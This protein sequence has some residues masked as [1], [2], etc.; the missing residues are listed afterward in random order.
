MRRVVE[1]GCGAGPLTRAS[2]DANFDVTGIDLS[3]ELVHMARTACP[4]AEFQ[5]GS[6]YTREIPACEAIVAIGEPLTYHDADDGDA[7]VRDFF[8]RASSLLPQGALLIFDL[9]ELG[10]PP[11]SGR[12]WRAGED[13]AV[14]VEITEN[15]SSRTVV[16]E[17]ET[18]RKVGE[19][20]RRGRE[21][22]RV[23][24][25]ETSEV[26]SWLEAAGFRVSTDRAFGDFRLP[27]RRHAFFCTRR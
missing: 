3:S 14:L 1:V 4:G 15:Q 21:V 24:L 12:S 26:C 10:Q 5:V 27:P 18:F 17:I 16:R 19:A 7:D 23:R 22:H 9:I 6:I 11:L 8:Q 2:V 20:Y 25:F 13:W